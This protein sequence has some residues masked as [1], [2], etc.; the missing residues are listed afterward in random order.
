MICWRHGWRAHNTGVAPAPETNSAGDYSITRNVEEISKR[1]ILQIFRSGVRAPATTS[2]ALVLPTIPPVFRVDPL[3]AFNPRER[4]AK[5]SPSGVGR[6]PIPVQR[7]T[8]ASNRLFLVPFMRREIFRRFHFFRWNPKRNG[9]FTDGNGK[10]S[11]G[12]R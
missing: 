2:R 1:A 5:H 4:Q 3:P 8:A 6:K 12:Q 9:A 11:F 10:T 7:V